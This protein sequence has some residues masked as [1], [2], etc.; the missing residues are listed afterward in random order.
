MEIN[1]NGCF[2][3][4]LLT[5]KWGER[6]ICAFGSGK[7]TWNEL[8]HLINPIG[9]MGLVYQPN[10]SVV[11]LRNGG[12]KHLRQSFMYSAYVS[13]K[14]PAPRIAENSKLGETR[15]QGG[16]PKGLLGFWVFFVWRCVVYCWWL[17]SGDHQ[18]RLLVHPRICKV[19]YI[20]I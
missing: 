12:T 18:L 14:I 6:C 9:S 5:T 17:K 16:H 1:S 2:P 8:N 13:R 10:I 19:L 4:Y 7:K 3:G 11:Y 15:P 20:N